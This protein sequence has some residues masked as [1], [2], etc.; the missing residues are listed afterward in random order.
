[1]TD[2]LHGLGETRGKHR[3]YRLM[4][5]EKLRSQTSY[6][7]RNRNRGG[8]AAVTAPNHIQRQLDVVEPSMGNGD[9]VHSDV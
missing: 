3:V 5:Q 4:R 2:V 7:R 9:N 8:S 6:R 1:M